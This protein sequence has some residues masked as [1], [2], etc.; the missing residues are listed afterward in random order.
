MN[1]LLGPSIKLGV[2]TKFTEPYVITPVS[3]FLTILPM[4][5]PLITFDKSTGELAFISLLLT[6]VIS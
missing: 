5:E 3:V 6:S 2:V 1:S 4:A